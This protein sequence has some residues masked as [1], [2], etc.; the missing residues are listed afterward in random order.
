[1]ESAVVTL[2][3]QK[4]RAHIGFLRFQFLY[5]DEVSAGGLHPRKKPFLAAERIP[6]RLA[7]MMSVMGIREEKQRNRVSGS[8]NKSA[9]LRRLSA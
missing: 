3:L 4:F 8:A 7:E 6:F 1:M 9:A 5:A 2:G